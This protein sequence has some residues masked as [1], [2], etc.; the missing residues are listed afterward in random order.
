NG[1]FL[2]FFNSDGSARFDSG[3]GNTG[4]RS[5]GTITANNWHHVVLRWSATTG[6]QALFV[7]GVKYE[8]DLPNGVATSFPATVRIVNNYSA[9]IDDLRISSCAR[10]DE[11]IL[12]AY[13]SNAPLPV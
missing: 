9:W 3:P 13:Q 11:E 12:A 7:N 10:T 1:R 6:K 2:L 8:G 4:P 5:Y